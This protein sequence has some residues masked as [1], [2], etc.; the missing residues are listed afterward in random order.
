MRSSISATSP[1]ARTATPTDPSLEAIVRAWLL[2]WVERI[3]DA[4]EELTALDARIG[5]GDHGI[6]M[7]RGAAQVRAMLDETPAADAA[8]LLRLSGR[9]IISS[10]G[11]AAG[12]LYGTLLLDAAAALDPAAA[13]A[14]ALA[15]I[16][17]SGAAGVGRRGRSTTG[18]KTMLDTLVPAG[19]AFAG[20][21]ASGGDL[22]T[23][24]FAA[25]AAARTGCEATRPMI[26]QRGRASYLGVRAVGHLD[27]GAVSAR[28]LIEALGEA[29]GVQP[30]PGATDA[31]AAMR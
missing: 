10:V 31:G 22:R 25:I 4:A 7:S 27:P 20:C 9:R 29:L 14:D 19:D 17:A 16:L 26:A 5:D 2:A 24:A 28:L 15:A 11:G 21:L 1:A 18:Q 8:E 30:E 23:A 13:A 3:A 12:P 6:N